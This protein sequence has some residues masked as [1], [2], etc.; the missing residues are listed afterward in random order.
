[1]AAEPAKGSL[2]L[3][4]V[5]A[6]LGLACG[7]VY[8]K[9]TGVRPTQRPTETAAADPQPEP[10]T[11]SAELIDVPPGCEDVL[12]W[13]S[14]PPQ[15]SQTNCDQI[16]VE[17]TRA[18]R[19]LLILTRYYFDSDGQEF[20]LN[21][22]ALTHHS[23]CVEQQLASLG[24]SSAVPQAGDLL[25]DASYAQIRSALHTT[26]VHSI[27]VSCTEPSCLDCQALS[28]AKCRVDPVCTPVMATRF[29]VERNCKAVQYAGCQAWDMEC[30]AAL[31][32]A[33]DMAGAC[34]L[35]S[36][37]CVP[38]AFGGTLSTDSMCGYARFDGSGSCAPP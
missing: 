34:W 2:G 24:V 37:T 5:A 4:W 28:E 7:G 16:S 38:A 11:A 31:T 27:E 6:W 25:V 3:C 23:A 32:T 15:C 12:V 9:G 29:D 8:E 30:G 19:W 13:R 33:V 35:F 17:A 22:D 21:A 1:M 36:D 10:E 18:F 14:E 20:E 26:A